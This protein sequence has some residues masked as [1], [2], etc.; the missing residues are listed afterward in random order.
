MKHYHGTPLGGKR[1]E[2]ARFAVNR[3][4]LIPF[5][6][7]EDLPIVAEA[8]STFVFD[9]GAF[10]AWK[11]GTPIT[12]WSDYYDWCKEWCRH[13]GFEWALIPDVIDGS[14]KDNDALIQE[15]DKRMS[16]PVRVRGV[17]VWHF[18]E[19]LERL[20]RLCSGRWH[21]VALGSSG[22]WPTP[23]TP[24]WWGRM[25]EIMQVCCDQ[26]GRPHCK[27]HGLR[28]L[29][30]DIFQKLPLASADSTNV[31]QNSELLNRFGMYKPP[32]Q[33]QRREVIASRIE[34]FS[35]AP[36]WIPSSETQ[37]MLY[38]GDP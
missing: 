28:M 5:N 24:K 18:H 4:F 14:E 26:H 12:D 27:L 13:P 33:S 2:I 31:A 29:S 21:T 32:T 15:W 25:R 36:R 30:P 38:Q 35:S 3:H 16:H 9:N 10:T 23:G 20:H 7:P 19:S 34:A 17:P 8:A 11:S 6:R 1:D 37:L 22:E